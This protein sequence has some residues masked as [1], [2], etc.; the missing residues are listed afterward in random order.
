MFFVCLYLLGNTFHIYT[1]HKS[2]K[3]LLTQ[4]IQTPEQHKWL[5]KLMGFSFEIHYKPGKENV[6][7][8]ALSCM[9]NDSTTA[10]CA[11]VNSPFFPLFT[12]LQQ[13]YA[14][15]SDGKQLVSKL[16]DNS[17]MQQK[18]SSCSSRLYCPTYLPFISS[19]ICM[20]K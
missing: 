15:R 10:I 18:F 14:T 8:D 6:I 9:H 4:T 16:R 5:T 2:L 7:V 19:P 11:I 3:S 13:F 12:Q 17:A 20:L 1:D